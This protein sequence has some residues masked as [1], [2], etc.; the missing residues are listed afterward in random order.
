[1][2]KIKAI[3]GRGWDACNQPSTTSVPSRATLMDAL[4]GQWVWGDGYSVVRQDKP[5]LD[6]AHLQLLE[7]GFLV[8]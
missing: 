7:D 1:M 5:L 8:I 6:Y 2:I 4:F 3:R